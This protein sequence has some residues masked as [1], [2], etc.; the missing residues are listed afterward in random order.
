MDFVNKEVFPSSD[1]VDFKPKLIR[2]NKEG[3]FILLKEIIHQQDITIVNIY[4]PN[5]GACI[6]IKQTFL[7]FKNQIDHNTG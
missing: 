6:Y 2:S 3:H 7:N 4:A 5:N 1:D